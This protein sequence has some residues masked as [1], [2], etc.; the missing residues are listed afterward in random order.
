M[1]ED[2]LVSV[3]MTTFQHEKYVAKALDSVLMQNTSFGI[4]ILVAD[5]CSTDGTREILLEYKKKYGDR[6]KLH[7]RE[8]NLG[9]T[10]NFYNMWMKAAG[11]YIAELEG[12]D[13][14]TDEYKLEKQAGYLE[15]HP[16]CMGVFHKCHFV[17]EYGDKLHLEYKSMYDS[18]KYYSIKDLQK[19]TLPGHTA[20]FMYRNILKGSEGK[21]NFFY[22]THNLVGD[23]TLYCILLSEGYL[24]Y[25]DED[26]SA[27]RIVVRKNGT[28]AR[29]IS[30]N[31][32]YAFDMWRYYCD[33]EIC[34]QKRLGK[35]VSLKVRRRKEIIKAYGK[36]QAEK[37]TRNMA[38][39]IKINIMEILWSLME[40]FILHTKRRI[41]YV[42]KS[43]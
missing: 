12:D 30:A 10:K 16:K 29:S 14:W 38:V 33:L 19:G 8:K 26:M 31:N 1:M 41:K 13:Y 34:M 11:K 23:Q 3:V 27:K 36:L 39:Y 28:N 43:R 17:G 2:I 7:L 37:T 18:K 32:N 4:E 5:D 35:N 6:I 20:A 22:H 40:K 9:A 15:S 21:Y 25:I 24:G 42:W